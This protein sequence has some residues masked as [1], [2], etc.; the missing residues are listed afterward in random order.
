MSAGSRDLSDRPVRAV[1]YNG[2]PSNDDCE[3]TAVVRRKTPEHWFMV[4][5]LSIYTWPVDT[6]WR[7]APPHEGEVGDNERLHEECRNQNGLDEL[8]VQP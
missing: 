7:L 2:R 4:R 6:R 8:L 1:R 5:L 3:D